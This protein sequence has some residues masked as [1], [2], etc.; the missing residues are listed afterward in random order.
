VPK[1]GGIS[2]PLFVGKINGLLLD[3][4]E[5]SPWDLIAGKADT[6][7]MDGIGIRPKSATLS[8]PEELG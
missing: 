5:N 4:A 8:T 3:V 6:A 2:W 7:T 1:E